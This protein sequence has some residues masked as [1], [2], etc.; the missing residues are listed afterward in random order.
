MTHT[1]TNRAARSGPR[2]SA[3][4][5]VTSTA[6]ETL[7]QQ[8][9]HRYCH[10]KHS[11][12]G[13]WTINAPCRSRRPSLR[14]HSATARHSTSSQLP[15]SQLHIFSACT[16]V[17]SYYF[18]LSSTRECFCRSS[19]PPVPLPAASPLSSQHVRRSA[20]HPSPFSFERSR[21]S[22]LAQVLLHFQLCFLCVH[23]SASN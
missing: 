6:D 5:L 20:T 8:R 15:L 21:R 9:Q 1:C 4:V 18:L 23:S 14:H 3:C 17:T 7:R 10:N 13:L 2:E 16:P 12:D 19:S 22:R 11:D